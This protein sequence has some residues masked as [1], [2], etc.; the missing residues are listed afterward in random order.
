MTERGF[1]Q[2][3]HRTFSR[4]NTPGETH[5]FSRQNQ[6]ESYK[7]VSSMALSLPKQRSSRPDPTQ[8]LIEALENFSNVLTNDEKRQFQGNT[9]KP[10]AASVIEFVNTL[11]REIAGQ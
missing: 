7:I 10:D 8:N 5:D 1:L 11:T 4:S 2:H 6:F 3:S 9:T